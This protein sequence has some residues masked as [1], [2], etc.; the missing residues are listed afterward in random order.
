MFE[1]YTE[2]ARCVVFYARYEATRTNSKTIEPGHILLGLIREGH[3][4]LP[5]FLSKEATADVKAA[6]RKLVWGTTPIPL[7]AELPLSDAARE[8]LRHAGEESPEPAR[9]YPV[10]LLI[11][12]LRETESGA[13]QILLRRGIT[14]E[15]VRKRS[16]DLRVG[17][18]HVGPIDEE[19]VRAMSDPLNWS[20]S[21]NRPGHPPRFISQR[22]L[23]RS[24]LAI[25]AALAALGIIAVLLFRR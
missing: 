25:L 17:P 8:A 3:D 15:E 11:G 19:L 24:G 21:I 1:R 10:D 9:V 18:I 7:T 22:Q 4:L 5:C 16:A 23:I 14:L 13:S 6:A 12:L 2:S 20:M